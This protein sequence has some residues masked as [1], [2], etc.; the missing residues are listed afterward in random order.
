MERSRRTTAIA[1][2]TGG[3]NVTS[4]WVLGEIE[5]GAALDAGEAAARARALGLAEADPRDDLSGRDAARK[6]A[7]LAS[8]VIG[9]PVDCDL[10][11]EGI[12][13]VTRADV[14]LARERGYRLRPIARIDLAGGVARGF[15]APALVRADDPLAHVAGDASCVRLEGD[16]IGRV[17][18][19]GPGAGAVPTAAS[20]VDDLIAAAEGPPRFFPR[21]RPHPALDVAPL[22]RIALASGRLYRVLGEG[23][24][25]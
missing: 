23:G 24:A 15:S 20:L 9:E 7:V 22:R 2:V 25:R 13:R 18:L 14:A 1:R 16:P 3:L 17:D 19:A 10:E 21:P 8:A 6:L 12:E 11:V 4:N 5:R